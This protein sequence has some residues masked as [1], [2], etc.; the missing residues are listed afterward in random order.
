MALAINQPLFDAVHK[1]GFIDLSTMG[2]RLRFARVQAGYSIEEAARE[3]GIL[4]ERIVGWETDQYEPTAGLKLVNALNLYEISYAWLNDPNEEM[5]QSADRKQPEEGLTLFTAA[6]FVT[7]I[8]ELHRA[9][10]FDFLDWWDLH[11]SGVLDR[12][13]T[14]GE[15]ILRARKCLGL[16][17]DFLDLV[18]LF[19]LAKVDEER[20]QPTTIGQMMFHPDLRPEHRLV[21]KNAFKAGPPAFADDKPVTRLE[22][23][24]EILEQMFEADEE[25]RVVCAV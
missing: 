5:H 22:D 19:D 6:R 9:A 20:A 15:D 10:L 13:V 8:S 7:G 18:R 3:I 11:D 23:V 17:F 1:T 4:A 16:D 25:E 24:L 21:L 14:S 12:P 2:K